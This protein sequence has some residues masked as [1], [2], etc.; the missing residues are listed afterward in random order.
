M[1]RSFH[2]NTSGP[3]LNQQ[4]LHLQAESKEVYSGHV[5]NSVLVR[6]TPTVRTKEHDTDILKALDHVLWL[7]FS[8]IIE[9][10]IPKDTMSKLLSL[11]SIHLS[12]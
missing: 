6:T 11:N 9:V 4:V 5:A 7:A 12:P 8:A 2:D 10:L 1:I 3:T